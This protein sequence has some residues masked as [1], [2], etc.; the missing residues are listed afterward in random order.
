M[1]IFLLAGRQHPRFCSQYRRNA[2]IH[3]NNKRR[4]RRIFRSGGQMFLS[5][6]QHSASVRDLVQV[7]L[8]VQLGVPEGNV[9]VL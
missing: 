6:W 8:G 4:R 2:A 5:S 7:L 9:C 1:K 3:H